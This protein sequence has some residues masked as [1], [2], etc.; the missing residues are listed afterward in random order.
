[1]RLP[2]QD[3]GSGEGTI[4]NQKG[5][6]GLTN[7]G[8]SI[9]ANRLAPLQHLQRHLMRAIDVTVFLEYLDR[10]KISFAHAVLS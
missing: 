3:D 10:W 8:R 7:F 2:T 5:C 1:M 6:L 4:V 9:A